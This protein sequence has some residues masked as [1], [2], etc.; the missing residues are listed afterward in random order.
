MPGKAPSHKQGRKRVGRRSKS[1]YKGVAPRRSG[2][3]ASIYRNGRSIYLGRYDTKE[4]AAAAYNLAATFLRG[5]SAELNVLPP[6]RQPI[7]E[8]EQEIRACVGKRLLA[9]AGFQVEHRPCTPQTKSP[10]QHHP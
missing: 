8:R 10:E 1:G 5:E 3:V 7:P 6:E 4:D 2:W 9:A